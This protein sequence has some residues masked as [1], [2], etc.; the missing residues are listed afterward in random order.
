MLNT[1]VGPSCLLYQAETRD[2]S[3]N[4]TKKIGKRIFDSL[5]GGYYQA[6]LFSGFQLLQ[7]RRGFRGSLC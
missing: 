5:Q 4:M 3:T 6:V 7:L 1:E 2:I